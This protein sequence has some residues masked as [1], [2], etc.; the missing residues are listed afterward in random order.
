MIAT[1]VARLMLN[2][3]ADGARARA[4][5]AST[6]RVST[7]V[8]A[9]KWVSARGSVAEGVFAM[10]EF[11]PPADAASGGA[12]AHARGRELDIELRAMGRGRG[13]EGSVPGGE[14]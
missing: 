13:R 10:S 14:G 11:D 3:R 9:D 8:G 6:A 1:L 2:L 5:T 7:L 4:S 12:D